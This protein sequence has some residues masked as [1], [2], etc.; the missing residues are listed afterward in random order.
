MSDSKAHNRP[1][2]SI[3]VSPKT[4]GDCEKLEQALSNLV[5]EDPSLQIKTNGNQTVLSGMSDA[6]LKAICDRI[7]REYKIQL[8][9]GEPQVIYLETIRKSAEGEG[10][11]IRQTGGS[12]NY[13]H[14]RIRLTPKESGE[15][16]EF[17]NDIQ[18]DLI[19][20]KF[21]EPI[22]QGIRD[23][24]ELGVLYGYPIVDVTATLYDGSHHDTDSNEM[25]FKFAGSMAAKEAA[26]RA[27]PVLLEPVMAVEVRAPEEH[28]GIIIRDM[29]ARRGRIEG[30]EFANGS[31]VIR[32]SLPLVEM[33]GYGRDLHSM[34]RGRANFL[35]QFARYEVAPKPDELGGGGAGI[36]ANKPNGPKAGIN[37]A[38]VRPDI[39]P[40]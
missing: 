15:G 8:D 19:P 36:T 9:V 6:H 30:I 17:V 4:G 13:G 27:S 35:M 38:A 39:E 1:I 3:A 32:A 20:R 7:L 12:G 28:M 25:A 34:T 10:K 2:I 21:I 14:C 40:E 22:E 37:S 18:G 31:K 24:L 29:N 16:C 33:F 11:Y 5:L 26:R 23:A